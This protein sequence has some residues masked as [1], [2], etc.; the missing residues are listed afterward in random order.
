MSVYLDTSVLASLFIDTD[1]FA[2]RATTFFAQADDVLIVSDFAATEFASV[3]SRLTRM[4]RIPAPR[5]RAI[6]DAFDIW[7]ARFADEEDTVSS[8]ILAATA[9]IRRL[10][11]NLRAPDAINLAIA[12]RLGAS[13]A[14]FD[15]RMAQNARALGINIE[16]A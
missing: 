11:L 12:L 3:L 14:T 6:F 15:R 2:T 4:N 9:I 8:D 5:T 7:R 16:A 1:V 13:V 10:D